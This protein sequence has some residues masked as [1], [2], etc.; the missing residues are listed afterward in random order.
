M[1]TQQAYEYMRTYLTREGAVRAVNDVGDCVYETEMKAR[2]IQRCAVGCLLTPETLN[3]YSE[4][5]NS[6]VREYCGSVVGLVD[7][8]DVPELAEVDQGFLSKAQELHDLEQNWPGGKFRVIKLDALA[9]EFG[10][11]VVVDK[12]NVVVE[13]TFA[14]A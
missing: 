7:Y 12:P 9:F 14:L 2:G 6:T 10:L 5:Q 1:N 4:A 11:K 8:F 3:Q 13:Q